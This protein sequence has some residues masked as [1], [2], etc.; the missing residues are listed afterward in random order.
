ME[1]ASYRIIS[2]VVGFFPLAMTTTASC[3]TQAQAPV[4]SP[5]GSGVCV[6]N[7][8]ERFVGK[9]RNDESGAE[10]RRQSGAST[11]RW[12]P[13]GMMVTMDF[14]EERVTVHLDR[15]NRIKRVVCG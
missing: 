14:R 13:E 4:A 3:S 8:L 6:P 9:S 15:S 5:A 12:V 2:L 11:I 10:I 1:R 7:G